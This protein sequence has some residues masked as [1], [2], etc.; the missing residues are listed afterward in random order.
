[1]SVHDLL[2]PNSTQLERD[3]V[4]SRNFLPTLAPSTE[5][6]RSAKIIR[7]AI[8]TSVQ[9]WLLYELGLAEIS[10][11]HPDLLTAIRE[12]VQWQWIKGTPQSILTAIGW[13]GYEPFIDEE[14]ERNST[15]WADYHL[16]FSP[17]PPDIADLA[18]IFFL[19]AT[20]TPA[21]SRPQRLYSNWDFRMLRW[22][23]DVDGWSEGRM[24]SDHSGIRGIERLEAA[25]VSLMRILYGGGG[26]LAGDTGGLRRAEHLGENGAAWLWTWSD[27]GIW[28]GR[29]HDLAPPQTRMDIHLG[30]VMAVEGEGWPAVWSDGGWS[31][32]ATSSG[33]IYLEV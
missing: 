31:V 21:R 30:G 16:G 18:D 12:G 1:M 17:Q 8:P 24:W 13:L 11:Y 7:S 29:W 9:P 33:G 6:L 15:F 26:A 3:L 25:Q 28:S 22:D 23:E 2:P 4:R 27:T 14:E 5:A 32:G 19:A 20:S 10:G